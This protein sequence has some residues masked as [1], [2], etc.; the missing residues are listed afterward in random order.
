MKCIKT[1]LAALSIALTFSTVTFA[2]NTHSG[3]A[4][5]ESGKAAAHSSAAAAHA[6]VGAGQVT[7]AASA[8]PLYVVG[9]VGAAS[10]EIAD[11]LMEAATAPAGT[12]LEISEESV[13]AGPAP[14]L[15][16]KE[17]I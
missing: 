6:V 15:A 3:R 16:L 2:G 13:T 7:S 1:L 9:A 12:P 17:R 11:E 4:V 14:N 10:T 5:H 8:V